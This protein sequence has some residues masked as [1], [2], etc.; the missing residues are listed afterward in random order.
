MLLALAE[1]EAGCVRGRLL[2]PSGPCSLPL[3]RGPETAWGE[4]ASPRG[5]G[6]AGRRVQALIVRFLCLRLPPFR[7]PSLPLLPVLCIPTWGEARGP[8]RLLG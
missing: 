6:F 2:V 8:R 3:G 7:L 4:C 5:P 1:A